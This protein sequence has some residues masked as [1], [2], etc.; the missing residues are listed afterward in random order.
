[1]NNVL[2]MFFCLFFI[3]F[4][5][6]QG[7]SMTSSSN[8]K[9]LPPNWIVKTSRQ[10]PTLFYYANVKTGQS[11]W[12]HPSLLKDSELKS[13]TKRKRNK[14][15][16][17]NTLEDAKIMSSTS[18]DSNVGNLESSLSKKAKSSPSRREDLTV[19]Q[20]N[21]KQAASQNEKQ[22]AQD[23]TDEAKS[24][25]G[26]EKSDGKTLNW[27]AL[28]NIQ[29]SNNSTEDK[30]KPVKFTIKKRNILSTTPMTDST[31]KKT[32]AIHPSVLL[33]RKIAARDLQL[34][35]K[36]QNKDDTKKSTAQDEVSHRKIKGGKE[37]TE[38][39]LVAK[40]TD[41]PETKTHGIAKTKAK[42]DAEKAKGEERKIKHKKITSSSLDVEIISRLHKT[43]KRE[44]FL[45][46][47]D[48]E[49]INEKKRKEIKM[50]EDFIKHKSK[51]WRKSRHKSKASE[52]NSSSKS[53]VKSDEEHSKSLSKNVQSEQPK[54]ES[55]EN[56]PLVQQIPSME[57][58]KACD[59]FEP[60]PEPLPVAHSLTSP[61]TSA[62]D[63]D[64]EELITEITNFRD[65]NSYLNMSLNNNLA[66]PPVQYSSVSIYFVV[67]TNVL[68][69]DTDFLQQLKSALVDG[70]EA[71]VV[72]PYVA[73]QEMD[74]LK[75]SASIGQACQAAVKWCNKHFE[76]KDP[77]V[78]GQTYSN[79]CS[80]QEKNKKAVS[81]SK[82]KN[83]N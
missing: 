28:E 54:E 14:T 22:E 52:Y 23:S 17:E 68:I 75:K 59:S 64:E 83:C 42:S 81:I 58:V 60:L 4:C 57:S 1:M 79:Y 65:S 32:S 67:D 44:E 35:T 33:A 77:R 11:T 63:I 30:P 19:S 36:S 45:D 13:I 55:L 73:L 51:K 43:E 69:R 15:L 9:I 26:K 8:K 21:V 76:A 6:L 5:F 78:L 56:D 70:R 18:S 50:Y 34:H 48:Q 24:L 66:V 41:T 53:E 82:S 20:S 10:Y 62:M 16:H 61:K 37:K 80:L 3:N 71:V 46:E 39:P 38:P 29:E 40:K 74:G 72:V 7:F 25:T 27:K 47:N 12:K 31:P 49:D 2:H